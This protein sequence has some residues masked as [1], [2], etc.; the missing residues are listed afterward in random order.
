[1]PTVPLSRQ[2]QQAWA[3]SSWASTNLSYA[4]HGINPTLPRAYSRAPR[5][6]RTFFARL[7]SLLVGYQPCLVA[8]VHIGTPAGRNVSARFRAHHSRSLTS[9]ARGVICMLG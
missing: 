5:S 2:P 7:N 8:G 6:A 4:G 3:G 1:M 9:G